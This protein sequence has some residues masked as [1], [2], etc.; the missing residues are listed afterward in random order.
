MQK[1]HRIY[2]CILA[3]FLFCLTNFSCNAAEYFLIFLV[4]AP[5]FDYSNNHSLLSTIANRK[6]RDVGHAWIYMQG[7]IDGAPMYIEGGHS[8]ELGI[9]QAKYFDGIMNYVAYGYANPTP[10]QKYHPI[11]EPNPIKY[12][13]ATQHD[14]F[15]QNGNGG[16]RPTC[17]AKIAITP[18]QF[19]R[20]LEFIQPENYDY[21]TYNL[22]RSQCSSFV[23]QVAALADF[24]IDY[25]VTMQI[26]Q[27]L[28]FRGAKLKLW[29]DPQYAALRLP[30]PDIIEDSLKKAVQ[31]GRAEDALAWY[32]GNR[33][34][35]MTR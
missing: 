6:N 8:G 15:F 1:N 22:S 17:A 23:A 30:S 14:G 2:Q 34:D 25:E 24:P 35:K 20:I 3:A 21:R 26:D 29:E 4:D 7:I 32:V 33:I 10:M 16:H 31:E 13:W 27:F 11:H 9:L 19:Q 28:Y 5:H 12:L 18:K